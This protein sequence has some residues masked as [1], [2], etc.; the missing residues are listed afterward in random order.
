MSR[1]RALTMLKFFWPLIRPF[2]WLARLLRMI[3][4][5]LFGQLSWTPPP[6]LQGG[7]VGVHLYRRALSILVAGGILLVFLLASGSLWMWRWYPVLPKTH[8]VSAVV[9]SIAL[10]ALEN[11]L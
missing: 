8:E 5:T 9:S 10:I 11:A 1:L 7:F 6:W 2:A 4:R 3:A